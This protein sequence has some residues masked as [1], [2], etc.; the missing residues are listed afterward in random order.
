MVYLSDKD[1]ICG[2]KGLYSEPNLNA[3]RPV[4]LTLFEKF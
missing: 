1:T 4:I 3:D 2:Q